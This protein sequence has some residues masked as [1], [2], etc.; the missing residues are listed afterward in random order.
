MSGLITTNDLWKIYGS[1]VRRVEA[2]RGVTISIEEG[3]ITCIAGASGSG[4]STLLS[5]LGLLSVP[6][7]GQVFFRGEPVE[8]LSEI[9]RTKIRKEEFGFIFQ[10][11]YLFSHLTALENT[12]LPL[13]TQDIG[14][15]EANQKS[16]EVLEKLNLKKRINF[17]V[18]E[19]SGGEAQR[20]AIA[21]ALVTDPSILIADEPSSNI[22]SKLTKE[23]LDLL[24]DLKESRKLTIILASHDEMVIS[25][26]D[27]TYSLYDGQIHSS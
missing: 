9:M 8:R 25:I 13:F 12:R 23:F 3:K 26:A 10:S 4:K 18:R 27:K 15:K 24:L 11:Q 20:V 19:L 22:D 14:L 21:R 2:L 6:S 16:R 5:Q 1:G 7:K 17:K